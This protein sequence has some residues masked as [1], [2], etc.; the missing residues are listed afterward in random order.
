MK[1]SCQCAGEGFRKAGWAYRY[2]LGTHFTV[3]WRRVLRNNCC[4]FLEHFSARE[5][6]AENERYRQRTLERTLCS[7]GHH[8]HEDSCHS[9]IKTIFGSLVQACRLSLPSETGWFLLAAGIGCNA[10]SLRAYSS[11]LEFRS[12]PPL[13]RPYQNSRVSFHLVRWDSSR[14]TPGFRTV[15]RYQ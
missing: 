1:N 5:R 11:S 8:G 12:P 10:A 3:Y 6:S 14:N 7:V 2:P 4:V 9:S 15:R 13:R